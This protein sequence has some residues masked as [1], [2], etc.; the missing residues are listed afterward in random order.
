MSDILNFRLPEQFTIRTALCAKSP[1][2]HT[3]NILG[4]YR[5]LTPSGETAYCHPPSASMKLS[6]HNAVHKIQRSLDP[7]EELV[8]RAHPGLRIP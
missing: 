4:I 5:R 6:Y 8:W 7:C 3:P 2:V 1:G